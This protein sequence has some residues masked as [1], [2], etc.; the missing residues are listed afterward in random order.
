MSLSNLGITLGA[1]GAK[2]CLDDVMMYLIGVVIVLLV[3]VVNIAVDGIVFIA[4]VII[5]VVIIVTPQGNWPVKLSFIVRMPCW[6][7]ISS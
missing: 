3:I 4:V 2:N 1:D 7:A 6:E 5:V